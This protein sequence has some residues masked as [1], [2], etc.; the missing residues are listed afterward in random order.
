VTAA[1]LPAEDDPADALARAALAAPSGP[2]ARYLPGDRDDLRDGLE[3][4][5][6]DAPR[7]RRLAL[8]AADPEAATRG[9]R[10]AALIRAAGADVALAPDRMIR[11]RGFATLPPFLVAEARRARAALAAWLAIEA[12]TPP[13]LRQ[14]ARPPFGAAEALRER[15]DFCACCGPPA[16]GAVATFWAAPGSR[17]WNCATCAPPPDDDGATIAY[18]RSGPDPSPAA[19][20]AA[21]GEPDRAHGDLP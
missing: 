19:P 3:V 13:E 20:R 10:L 18:G 4:G 9:W 14:H 1:P 6:R 2:A 5:F 7:Q 12:G 17:A 21:P 11:P 15:A 16:P 8:F